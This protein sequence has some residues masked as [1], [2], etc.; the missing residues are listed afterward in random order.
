MAA[1]VRR[2]LPAELVGIPFALGCGWLTAVLTGSTIAAALA[3]TW[4]E[5][6]GYYGVMLGR[7]LWNGSGLRALPRA[8]RNLVLEFGPAEGLDTLL[9]RPTLVHLGLVL[10][11]D[12]L[13]GIVAGKV[14]ADL[15]FYVPAIVSY[16]LLA[17]SRDA[18]TSTY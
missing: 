2:Y 10:A 7:E 8:L 14:A 12:P 16:E 17:R 18:N 6:V 5:N 9:V 13:T 15:V 1:W 3:A 11:P 4:G